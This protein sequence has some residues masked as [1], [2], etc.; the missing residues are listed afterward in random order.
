MRRLHFTI[1]HCYLIQRNLQNCFRI[2]NLWDRMV[3]NLV[4]IEKKM[5]LGSS[6]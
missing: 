6:S 3:E 4:L 1:V 5:D 2:Q